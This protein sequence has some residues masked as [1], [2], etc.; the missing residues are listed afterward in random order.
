MKTTESTGCPFA[1]ALGGDTVL[2]YPPPR[3]DPFDPPPLFKALREASVIQKVRLWNGGT[4]WLVTRYD[5]VREILNHPCVSADSNAPNYP[6]A[7]ASMDVVRKKYRSYV[8]MD[9]PEHTRRRRMVAG[10]FTVKRVEAL[11]PR[12]Q[13]HVDAMLDRVMAKPAPADLLDELLLPL[14]SL[15]ICELLGVEYEHHDFFQRAGRKLIS[16]KTP[17]DEAIAI[18]DELC[19]KFIGDLIDRKNAAPGDDLLSRLVVQYLRT[20]ELTRHELICVARMLL[21]AGHETTANT[22]A[23]GLLALL[24]NPDELALLKEEPERIAN[25]VNEILR[26]VDAGQS[27]RRRTAIADFDFRGVRFREGD[28]IIAQNNSANRDACAFANPD[29]LDLTRD[30]SGHVAFGY[31]IHQC[32]GQPLARL[33]MQVLYTTLFRRMPNVALAVPMSAIRFKEQQF[34]YGV[35]AIPVTW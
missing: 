10:E 3:S 12:I 32:Q 4:A 16:D 33:E 28:G 34:V 11:R 23:I 13:M 8:S 35:E 5:D 30:A 19:E 24:N 14:P 1:T 25:A 22:M 26:Y 29:D 31:G 18:T 17:H 6:G 7:S 20:G 15:V 27:G 2:E 9:P 21:Q